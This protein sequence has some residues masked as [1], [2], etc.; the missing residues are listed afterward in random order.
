MSNYKPVKHA[1]DIHE[2][3][4]GAD[5][6]LPPVIFLHGVIAS[7]E[8]WKD[9][10]QQVA[11]KTKRKVY[12]VDLRNHGD[13]E[14][15]DDFDLVI[16]KKDLLHF[17]ETVN[18]PKATI[19]GHSVGAIAAILAALENSD[20]IEKI[21][22]DEMRVS[23]LD[24]SAAAF[25]SA[26]ATFAPKALP[27]I[28]KDADEGEAASIVIK[29]VCDALPSESV[30]KNRIDELDKTALGLRKKP[31]G[32]YEFKANLE[33]LADLAKNVEKVLVEPEGLFNGPALFIYGD[34]SSF[35]VGNDKDRIKQHFPNAEFVEMTAG[36]H[37]IHHEK[38][39]EF[40]DAV[41]NF[42]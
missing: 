19:L 26:F 21:V 34:Q 30:K 7:K 16:L 37:Y 36:G 28:P 17:M 10:P 4:G 35:Q 31:D 2:P 33:N 18:C 15:S 1:Y 29:T 32:S 27:K 20:K 38:P 12:N 22:I 40:M 8:T 13:T 6:S 14:W 3:D 39:K 41:L 23:K 5:S 9:M 25:T 42:I 24:R 11:N